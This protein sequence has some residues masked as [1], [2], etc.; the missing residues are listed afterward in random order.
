MVVLKRV[1]LAYYNMVNIPFWYNASHIIENS[2]EKEPILL[3]LG[4]Q[5]AGAQIF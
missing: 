1:A 2:V 4:I 5:T 3:F